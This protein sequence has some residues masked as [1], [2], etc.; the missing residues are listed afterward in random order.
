MVTRHVLGFS[1]VGFRFVF[2]P[3]LVS[4]GSFLDGSRGE[5][6]GGSLLGLILCLEFLSNIMS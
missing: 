2:S 4:S 6:L 3:F 5:F 1:I